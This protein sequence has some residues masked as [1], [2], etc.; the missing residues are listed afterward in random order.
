MPLRSV[1]VTF[2]RALL[3]AHLFCAAGATVCFWSA[4][5]AAKGQRLHRASG[6]WFARFV[7]L[8]AT[9]GAT[10]AVIRLV[11]LRHADAADVPAAIIEQQTMWLVLY[12]LL[13]IVTP[14]QHGIA[15]IAAGRLPRAV[16]SR[17]HITLNI[18]SMLGS[19]VILTASLLWGR[20]LFLIVAPIGLIVGLRNLNYAI[21]AT[22]GRRDWEREHL[23]S[24]LTAGITLHTALLVFG[25]SRTLGLQ[26]TG[27]GSL[28]PWTVPALVGLPLIVW[29]RRRR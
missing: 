6:F 22:S 9:T 19:V 18:L 27:F 11:A 5:L 23:T 2:V 1:R 24:Q 17:R 20:W 10:L 25:T 4:A 16:R 8:T 21:R 12:V 29:W 26:L 15:V 3:G 14:V 28:W 13:I 7:Y